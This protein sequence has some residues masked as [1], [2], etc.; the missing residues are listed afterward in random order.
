MS[1]DTKLQ[2][3]ADAPA[4]VIETVEEAV[5]EQLDAN[6]GDSAHFTVNAFTSRHKL[7]I[8]S[9]RVGAALVALARESPIRGLVVERINPG[10]N[11][12]TWAVRYEE[13]EQ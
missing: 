9:N 2:P 6:Y 4:A 11:R 5:R 7:D 8:A 12:P 13:G 3:G 1:V 10:A